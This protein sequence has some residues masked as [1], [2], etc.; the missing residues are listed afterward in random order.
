MDTILMLVKERLNRRERD[1]YIRALIQ[2]EIEK[3]RE[4]GIRVRDTASDN[5]FVADMVVW[6]YQN[7]DKAGDMPLWLQTER[8]ERFLQ[9]GR[10]NRDT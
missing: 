10:I 7:R 1:E 2:A 8:R 4:E 5:M 9:D 3:L 6:R